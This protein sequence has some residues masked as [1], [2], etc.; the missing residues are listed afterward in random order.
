MRLKTVKKAAVIL[1]AVML[2]G[3]ADVPQ[4]VKDRNEELDSL[5]EVQSS[6]ADDT[7]GGEAA[8]S[9][10]KKVQQSDFGDLDYIRA[11]L[12]ED[13]S[14]KYGKLTVKRASAGDAKSMPTYKVE[15]GGNPSCDIKQL[16][17]AFFGEDYET[18]GKCE[19]ETFDAQK[20]PQA[21]EKSKDKHADILPEEYQYYFN[22]ENP[23]TIYSLMIDPGKKGEPTPDTFRSVGAH[24]N[25]LICGRQTTWKDEREFHEKYLTA[26]NRDANYRNSVKAYYPMLD[27][28]ADDS[29]KMTDGKDWSVKD[30]VKFAEDFANKAFSLNDPVKYNHKVYRVDVLEW[31]KDAYSY[32][33]WLAF[34]DEQGNMYDTDSDCAQHV[35][36][37]HVY[38]GERFFIT[39][40]YSMECVAKD[41][42]FYL[43]REL[44]Y[45][46]TDKVADNEK[47]LT[48]GGALKRLQGELAKHM[49][50]DFDSAMLCYCVTCDKYPSKDN[51]HLV[52][53]NEQI[54]TKTC[55]LTARPYWCFKAGNNGNICWNRGAYY[56][57]DAVTGD[58][59]I[60]MSENG[61]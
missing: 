18:K 34:C 26:H 12:K 40:Q 47:L 27:E 17:K 3:C 23:Y 16:G 13:A 28:L 35:E 4:N 39:P 6:Q 19:Y 61:A 8:D 2:A 38:K 10:G 31:D 14:K 30:A 58:V 5:R 46:Q 45:K 11:H 7:S 49:N 55:E 50:I 51:G 54:C 25:G 42:V 9:G 24:G 48:L 59:H 32:N 1:A 52:Q 43:R 37:Q 36:Q 15:V 60:T 57:V 20:V 29:Y 21:P 44:S 53:F 22:C 33:F 56:Y 41:E